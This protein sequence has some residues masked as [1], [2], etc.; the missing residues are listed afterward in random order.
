MADLRPVACRR[1]CGRGGRSFS[2]W[3]W[4][5]RFCWRS[6][7]ARSPRRAGL[8]CRRST[9]R[10][11][12]GPPLFGM[13]IW[14]VYIRFIL[15]VLGVF[16]GTALIA[17]EVEDK[18]ITYLF[19]RPIPRSAVFLGK[20]AAYLVCTTF[21]WCFRPCVIVYLPD[22]AARRRE[23][24]AG[25][26][27][28]GSGSGHADPRA[29]DLRGAVR[30]S[31]ARAS[32]VRSLSGLV[33]AFGWEQAVQLLP[34]YVKRATDR[35]LP[36]GAHAARDAQRFGRRRPDSAASAR[37]PRSGTSVVALLSDHGYD[38]MAGEQVC[39]EA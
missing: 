2:A 38:V 6:G 22:R 13:M 24:G 11:S 8:A 28:A 33:F 25:V 32:S 16:Y 37:C 9:A 14:L 31:W 7:S 39:A 19:T 4:A 34:G 36:A 20:Y 23:R 10:R 27:V 17:D 29:R 26:P 3:S 21:S 1:C 35:L 18:T 12:P 5:V 30:A 15:P